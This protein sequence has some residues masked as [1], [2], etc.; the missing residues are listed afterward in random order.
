MNLLYK[1]TESLQ[2]QPSRDD[3]R[4]F[5]EAAMAAAA[6]I[7]SA[8]GNLAAERR[9][10]IVE[11]LAKIDALKT[12][13]IY[14][15]INLFNGFADHIRSQPTQGR[16]HALRVVATLS[17][18]PEMAEQVVRIGYAVSRAEGRFFQA[19]LVRIREI[20]EALGLP[21]PDLCDGSYIELGSEHH[22][23]FIITMGNEKGGTG[24]S[25]IA[26]HMAIALLKLGYGVG[27]IDL[28][29]RQG[30]LSRYLAHREAFARV[31]GREIAVPA[32]RRIQASTAGKRVRAECEDLM[33]LRQALAELSQCQ[34]VVIDT[35][36]SD[37][38]LARLGHAN[39]DMLITPLNDTFLDVDVLARIDCDKRAVLAPSAYC[40]MVM[41]LNDRRLAS[42]RP[43]ID[44]IV[45]RNRL[46]HIHTHNKR[47]IASLLRQLAERT[48]FRLVPGFGERVIFHEMFLSGITLLDLPDKRADGRNNP[49]HAHAREE[50]RDLLEGVG[51]PEI[52]ALG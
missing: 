51:V 7:A 26:M 4:A 29:G 42:G 2:S 49:S 18:D 40:R 46:T 13:G 11:V 31:A 33:Q 21:V 39:A 16:R 17:E 36:G 27:A 43:A 23:P 44:W 38:H 22:R 35:P 8:D 34:A 1:L 32:Y 48:G 14:A 30:T 12:S 45:M 25:T 9:R 47:E 5:L 50:F 10:A 41:D 28:D 24:K 3:Q 52:A 6:L 19:E 15:A 37:S 20:A